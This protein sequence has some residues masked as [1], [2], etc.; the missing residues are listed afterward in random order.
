M[1]EVGDAD[2]ADVVVAPWDLLD[3]AAVDVAV[4][5]GTVTAQL[6]AG[7]KAGQKL[8]LPGQGLARADGSRGDLFLVV[9]LGLPEPLT[10][11]QKDLLRQL[12]KDAP[13]VRGGAA[14]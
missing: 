8:R 11:A 9:R 7:A 14:R 13:N 10:D 5:A 12:G 6:P 3:G 2:G 4:P 1:R